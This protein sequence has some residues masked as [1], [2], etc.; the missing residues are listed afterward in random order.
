MPAVG[1]ARV[2]KQLD[3]PAGAMVIGVLEA[4][5]HF[6]DSLEEC[7]DKLQW[8]SK[9]WAAIRTGAIV[10]GRRDSQPIAGKEFDCRIMDDFIKI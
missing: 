4:P 6:R 7:S 1:A 8:P 10:L 3:P 5:L 9:Y 2:V